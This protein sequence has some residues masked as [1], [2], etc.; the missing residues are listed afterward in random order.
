MAGRGPL[1]KVA[2]RRQR[3]SRQN[4]IN[5]VLGDRKAPLA[6]K[7]F[8]KAVHDAWEAYWSSDLVR[9]VDVRTDQQAVYRFFTLLDLRERAYRSFHKEP[10]IEGSHGQDVVNP[11]GSLML[12][13]DQEIRM[14]GQ[15][16]GMTPAARLRLGIQLGHARDVMERRNRTWQEDDGNQSQE[17]ESQ[18][19]TI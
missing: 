12:R 10:F 9:A 13:M 8:L 1:P 18:G 5:L 15:E 4:T 6:P 17:A 2:G 3:R 14:L 7:K 16:L 11:Q 19:A